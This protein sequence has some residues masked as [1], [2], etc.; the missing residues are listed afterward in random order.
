MEN[1]FHFLKAFI[2]VG[3]LGRFQPLG[4]LILSIAK[5]APGFKEKE[6]LHR[7]FISDRLKARLGRDVQTTDL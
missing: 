5:W 3:I 1:I 4:W 2:V 7:G 6:K